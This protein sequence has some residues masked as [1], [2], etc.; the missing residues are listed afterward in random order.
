MHLQHHAEREVLFVDPLLDADH[1]NLDEVGS[2]ALHRRIYRHAFCHLRFHAVAAVD[3]R[4]VAAAARQ[5][6]YVAVAVGGRLGIFDILL[7]ALVHIEVPG[8]KVLG[9]RHRDFQVAR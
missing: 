1:R 7:H 5:G 9:L 8:D 6:F 3:A 4:N 2:G